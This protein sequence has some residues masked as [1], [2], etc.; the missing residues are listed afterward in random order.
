MKRDDDSMPNVLSP[1]PC[2]LCP[3]LHAFISLSLSLF[4]TQSFFSP[5]SLSCGGQA[6]PHFPLSVAKRRNFPMNSMLH[7][8]CP[9]L[10]ISLS[11]FPLVPLSV[12]KRRNFPMNSMLHAPPAPGSYPKSLGL[13]VLSPLVSPVCLREEISQ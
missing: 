10:Y 5:P 9:M 11:P 2:A 13:L 8:P 12:A 7:A 1:E 4:V 6:C 3:M